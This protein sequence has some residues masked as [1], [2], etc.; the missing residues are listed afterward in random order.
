M[1]N[2]LEEL[3][4]PLPA[5]FNIGKKTRTAIG[6]LETWEGFIWSVARGYDYSIYDYTNDLMVRER[7]SEVPDHIS[8]KVLEVY[9]DRL[10]ELD[11]KFMEFTVQ[12]DKPL[13]ENK[14]PETSPWWFRIP[15]NPGKELEQ[16]LL[17]EGYL[18]KP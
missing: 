12:V 4:T 17:Y 5:I 6:L 9:M 13:D 11:K 3:N 16:D 18:G 7:L 1:I 2:P 8:P 15:K 14:S 10:T